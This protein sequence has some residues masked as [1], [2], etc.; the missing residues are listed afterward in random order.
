MLQRYLPACLVVTWLWSNLRTA[1]DA[2]VAAIAQQVELRH[3][4]DLDERVASYSTSMTADTTASGSGTAAAT[5]T[6]EARRASRTDMAGTAYAGT[7]AEQGRVR[8]PPAPRRKC[9]LKR[10][11]PPLLAS[12]V[13]VAGRRRARNRHIG[14]RRQPASRI[15]AKLQPPLRPIHLCNAQLT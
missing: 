6:Y 8:R 2:A 15:S 3:I 7:A 4:V 5:S 13:S 12:R 10:A 11:N 1:H 9:S 14:G